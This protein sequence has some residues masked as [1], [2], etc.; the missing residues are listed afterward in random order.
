MVERLAQ[1]IVELP[2]V[3]PSGADQRVDLAIGHQPTYLAIVCQVYQQLGL[4]GDEEVTGRCLH[5]D[6]CHTNRLFLLAGSRFL[7]FPFFQLLAVC[8]FLAFRFSL[9]QQG[10]AVCQPPHVVDAAFPV[11][12]RCHFDSEQVRIYLLS[13]V[14]TPYPRQPGAE[15]RASCQKSHVALTRIGIETDG[16]FKQRRQVS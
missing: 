1:Q 14:N 11:A 15:H 6:I 4:G 16:F 5:R 9:N 2:V 10:I 3:L 7:H 8:L 12:R 13:V